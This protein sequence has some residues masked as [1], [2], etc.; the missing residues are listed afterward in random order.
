MTDFKILL[1]EDSVHNE[2]AY[3][4]TIRIACQTAKLLKSR[5]FG[6]LNCGFNTLIHY[7]L[8]LHEGAPYKAIL[9][10]LKEEQTHKLTQLAEQY[11]QSINEMMASQ[12]LRLDEEQEAEC[13]ALRQQLH[14]EMELLDAYQN[15]TKAQMENQHE[16]EVQ[17]LEQKAS[18]RRAHLEQKVEMK[19]EMPLVSSKDIVTVE[20]VLHLHRGY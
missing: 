9:K 8:K 5:D 18:L 3:R 13:Q 20:C 10:S 19:C 11:E 15:K 6:A 2:S 17:K 1:H 14:Q 7:A 4:I 12:S 16:R